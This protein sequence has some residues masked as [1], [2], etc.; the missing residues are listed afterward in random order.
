[1]RVRIRRFLLA[2]VGPFAA[3]P[4][5]AMLPACDEGASVE[6]VAPQIALPTGGVIAAASMPVGIIP[7]VLAQQE[8]PA[9]PAPPAEE[10]APTPPAPA[11]AQEPAPDPARLA[12]RM[13]ALVPAARARPD[14]LVPAD[15]DDVVKTRAEILRKRRAWES[16][17]DDLASAAERYLKAVGADGGEPRALWAAGL[18]LA[19]KADREPAER[20]VQ[21]RVEAARVLERSL[22][23]AAKDADFRGDAEALLGRMLVALIAR[24]Q[25]TPE[26]AVSHLVAAATILRAEQRAEEIGSTLVLA[27]HAL[28]KAKRP[29]LAEALVAGTAADTAEY[30]TPEQTA[31]LR[32]Q[33]AAVRTG[34]GAKLPALPAVKD[35]DGKPV[36]WAAFKGKVLL[37]HFF[38]AGQPNGYPTEERDAETVVRPAYDELHPRGLEVISIAMDWEMPPEKVAQTKA[39][40]DEWGVKKALCTGS[41]ATVRA[42]AEQQGFAWPWVRSGQWMNDPVSQALGGAGVS[43]AHAVLVDA[44]GVI[45][46]RGDAPFVG[47]V[48]EARKHLPAK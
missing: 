24:G 27:I 29:D 36:D 37:L 22:A 25:A 33:V 4:A 1:M 32:T 47:L 8:P 26:Q 48:E 19:T 23:G 11:P 13:I 12:E 14:T 30:G 15:A 39:N 5:L 41:A 3:L 38:R 7:P 40:W 9:P 20:A 6:T 10:P 21:M 45:R 16:D 46:W 35:E 42:F 2:G 28:L 17:V 34:V 31:A 18:G 43:R 44:D